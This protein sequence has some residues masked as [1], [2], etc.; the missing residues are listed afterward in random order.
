MRF[1]LYGCWQ[2][3]PTLFDDI[4]LPDL[5]DKDTLIN[6][7]MRSSG[8]LFPY[9]QVPA[10]LKMNITFWFKRMKYNFGRLAEAMAIEYSPV[11]NYDRYEH[12]ETNIEPLAKRHS[13]ATS[14]PGVTST[15]ESSKSSY[16]SSAY[17]PNSEMVTKQ[18]GKD[19]AESESWGE[20]FD[21]TTFE[22]HI[23][24]NIGVTTAMDTIR[25]E[26]RLRL[27]LDFYRDIAKQFEKEFLL[28][29]Y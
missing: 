5:V 6:E 2:Y 10:Q 9:H 22:T 14:T 24:G 13:K 16:N 3:D 11:E 28:Q 27:D 29:V 20:G 18:T 23:H 4:D 7:I 15:T 17:Q 8:E 21:K 12:S 26:Y 19:V 1:S 25:S